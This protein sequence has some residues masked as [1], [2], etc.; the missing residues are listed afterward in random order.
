[1]L[2][3]MK[4]KFVAL[5]TILRG[6]ARAVLPVFVSCI[7]LVT[8]RDASAQKVTYYHNDALGSP[9][10]A[11]DATG[12]VVWK[13][14]YHPYGLPYIN[15]SAAASERLG[16]A[17]KLYD[18]STGL[19]Y[20]GARYYEP[21]VGRFLSIDPKEPDEGDLHSLNRYA[22]ANNNP[23][24]FLDPDGHSPVDF[25][26]LVFDATKLAIAIY[27]GTGVREAAVDVA[28]SVVGAISPVPAVGQALK[29]AKVL[30]RAADAA[31]GV[32]VV[33]KKVDTLK[34][35]PFARE[36]IP[37]HRGKPTAAEQQQVNE[38][39][40]KHGCHTCGTKDPGTKSGNAIADHQPAQ[41]L[42]EPTIFLPHCN[43][44]KAI[45]GGQVLQELRRIGK[46]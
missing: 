39:M 43:H 33:A 22:Y 5:P 17:G 42:G 1:M 4:L 28:F 19:S 45:Q 23:A 3:T 7:C 40:N 8:A 10:V 32:S 2:T 20:M 37:A 26:F 14:T 24:R 36:S 29:A 25:G 13:E 15:S 9:V 38:L 21:Y 18:R 27:Q 44:C 46:E 30:E 16:F 11:T 35:G 41:A 12:A 6:T 34:M 31:H